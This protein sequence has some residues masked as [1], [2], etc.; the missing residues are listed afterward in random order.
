MD[1]WTWT[2]TCMTC[3]LVFCLEMES[4][5]KPIWPGTPTF[6]PQPLQCKNYKPEPLCPLSVSVHASAQVHMCAGR[7]QRNFGCHSPG[8]FHF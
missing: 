2:R 3:N 5:M 1:V 6:L 7:G 4:T 8:T